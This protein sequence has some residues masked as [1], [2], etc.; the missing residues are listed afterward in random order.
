MPRLVIHQEKIPDPRALAALCPFGALE[1]REGRVSVNAA[2]K[3]C[4]ICVK[5]GPAGAVEYLED[6][7][8]P[9][10]RQS[11]VAGGGGLRRPCR[12][13]GFIPSRSS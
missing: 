6:A 5:K 13:G 12:P 9:R 2:C 1:E 10:R 11:G 8:A 4:R 7:P 3:M